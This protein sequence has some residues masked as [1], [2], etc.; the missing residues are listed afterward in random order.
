MDLARTRAVSS[1][2]V[3][4]YLPCTQ[5]PSPEGGDGRGRKARKKV[6]RALGLGKKLQQKHGQLLYK[7]MPG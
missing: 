6:K 1:I 4:P 7:G 2:P 3:A 5:P